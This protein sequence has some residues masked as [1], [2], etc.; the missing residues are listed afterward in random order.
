MHALQPNL[1]LGKLAAGCLRLTR[2]PLLA[3][4]G[5]CALLVAMSA[6]PAFAQ[7]ADLAVTKAGAPLTVGTGAN[8]TYTLSVTNAGPNDGSAVTLTDVLPPG[9]TFVSG[10][11]GCT[12]ALGV[13]TCVVGP[14]VANTSAGATIVVTA[15]SCGAQLTNVVSVA[16]T[17]ID[18]NLL[19][20]TNSAVNTVIDMTAPVIG[21]CP[22]NITGNTDAGVCTKANV[23]WVDPTA[24]DNCTASPAVVCSPASGSTFN[25][26]ATIVTC[27]A[28]DAV[29]LTNACTFT[30]TINDT[31]APVIGACPAN[32]AGNTD[33]G[34]CTKAN[35][36]WTVPGAT[37]NCP[38]VLVACSP[39]SG[40]T[41]AKGATIV[42]CTAT[43][44]VGLTNA[45]TFTVTI[46]DAQAPTIACPAN[47]TTNLT[48]GCTTPVTFTNPVVSDNCPGATFVCVP[49]NGSTFTRGTTTVTCTPTDASL[50]VGAVCTFTVTVTAAAPTISAQPQ[51]QTT[52]MGNG[53]VFSVTAAGT[54]TLTYQWRSNGVP[55]AGATASSLTLANLNLASSGS[56]DV[57]VNN[58]A[59][60]LTS[61]AA[62]LTVTPIYGLSFDFDTAGQYTNLPY[63]LTWNNWVNS[64]FVN[65]PVAMF[66]SP[67]GGVGPFPGSGSLDMIPANASDNTSVLI[68]GSYDFSLPGKTVFASTMF[69]FKTPVTAGRRATQFGFIT[70]TNAGINDVSPQAFM[71]V[72]LQSPTA[73]ANTLE[74]RTQRRTSGGGLQESVFTQATGLTV[75]NWYKLNIGFTN[76]ANLGVSNFGIVAV[77]QDMGPLGTTPGAVVLTMSSTT[78]TADIV[79]FKN[80]F[81]ALRSFE[82][83]GV[84]VRDNTY[85]WTTPGNIA[86]V[87]QPKNLTLTQG[88]RGTFNAMV[89][90]D[91]PYTYQWEKSTDGGATF[92]P[93]AGARDWKYIVPA[94]L[95]TDTLSQ[96]RV[97]VVGPANTVTSTPATLT[98][99]PQTLVVVSA[100][101]VD[102]STVGVMFNQPVNPATAENIANYTINGANPVA[103]RV[104]RTSLSAAGPEGI[105]V[106]L[107]PASI[108]SG[109]FTVV[110][111]GVQDL[112]GGVVGGAN[113]AVGSVANLTGVDVNPITA[114]A[115]ENYSFGPGQFIVTGGGVDLF[116]GFDSFRFVYTTRTG[117]FDVRYRIPF[118][119]SVRFTEKGGV[120]ARWT[121]EPGSPGAFAG[122]NPGPI[123][124]LAG[125]LRSFTE[126]TAKL[127]FGAGG[128]S[129]GNNTRLLQPNVWMRFR[130]AGNS[131]LRY[132]SSDGVTWSCDGQ[133]SQS[134][135]TPFP[136][137]MLVGLAVC[138]ARNTQPASVQ[139]E[140]FGD[141]A[142]YP[143]A[144][145][146]I[147]A[148]P[149]NATNA[150]GSAA[151]IT[152]LTATVTG[153]GIPGQGEMVAYWQRFDGVGWTNMPTAGGTNRNLSV[154]TVFITDNGAQFRAILQAPGVAPVTTAVATL[155]VTDTAVPTVASVAVGAGTVVPSYP[156]SEVVIT[157]S[158][159][160]TAATAT[161]LANYAVTNAAGVKLTVLSASF[162]GNDPRVIVLKVDGQLGTG[163]SSVG[164]SGIRDLNNNLLA[165]VVRTYRSFA[166]SVAPVVIEVY[167]DIGNAATPISALTGNALFTAG[168][169]TYITYSNIFGFNVVSGFANSQ[170][171]YGTKAYTYFL[172]PTNGNYKFWIRSDDVAQLW[173]NTS[174]TNPAGRV[175]IC[176]NTAANGNYTVGTAPASSITNIALVA[177]SPVYMEVLHKEGTGGDGWSVTWT[178]PTVNTAP[179]VT[180]LMPTTALQY[181]D[182][183]AP[184]TPVIAEIYTGFNTFVP[185]FNQLA[186]LY[187]ATNIPVNNYVVQTPGF[188]YLAGLPA[189][190]T[191]QKYFGVQPGLANTRF[192]GYL[193][194]V[195]SYFVAPSNGL[196]RFYCAVDDV[197]QLWMNTNAV[198]STDPAGKTLIGQSANAFVSTA[199]QLMGQNISLVAGQKYYTEVLYRE[200]GGGDGIRL[201]VRSQADTAVPPVTEIIQNNLLEYPADIGR[202]GM[203]GF[204]HIIS[205][206]S[207]SVDKLT[208]TVTEG[209]TL[210]LLPAGI[211]GSLPYGGF[212][213]TKNGVRI[214]ENSFTNYTMPLTLADNGAVFTVQVTNFWSSMTKS[215]TV[216]VLP[217]GVAPTVTRTVGWRYG[218][219][220]TIQFSEPVDALSA[221][222]L[223]NY[224]VNNGLRLLSATLD[225][226]RTMLSVR[227]STQVP[228]TVYTVTV[229]GVK[230]RTAGNTIAA[231]TMVNFSTWKIGGNGILVELFTNIQ[232]S[233][234]ADLTGTTKFQA[235]LPDVLYYTNV[236]GAGLFAG[237]SLLENYGAR[238][239]GYFIPTNT[240]LYRFYI[241]G[242]DGCQLW[243]N[244]NNA[245]SQN[246]AG[247]T[248]LI[249]TPTA[250]INIGNP[251][252]MSAPVS[253]NQGQAYYMEGLM[254]EGGG[255]D[256]FQMT[257]RPTDAAGTVIGTLPVDNAV[258]ENTL[259]TFFGGVP[260]DPTLLG[261]VTGPPADMFVIESDLVTLT[262]TAT[263]PPSLALV[264]AY[265]W[266]RTNGA[267]GFTNI[268]GA[269]LSSYSFYVPLADNDAHY[270]ALFS[271][272]GSDTNF[273]TMFHVTPDGTAPFLQSVGSVDGWSIS[274]RY[275]ELVDTNIAGDNF[276]YTINNDVQIGITAIELQPGGRAADG[277]SYRLML[278][279][280]LT[281]PYTV[282]AFGITDRS[283]ALNTGDSDVAGQVEGFVALD[284]GA[285]TQV[286]ST[287]SFSSNTVD[288]VAGGADIWGAA[289]SGHLTLKQ[290]TGDFDVRA[291]VARLT[292]SA[293]DV[294]AKAGLM[295]REDLNA[296][297]R[298]L[299]QLANP[300]ASISGRDIYEN[301]RR[302][303]PGNVTGAWS[304]GTQN[305]NNGV[306]AGVPNAWVRIKRTGNLFTAYRSAD[307]SSWLATATN[308]LTFSNTVYVGFASTAHNNAGPAVNAD[309]RNIYIPNP[310]SFTLQPT[311]GVQTVNVHDPVSYTVTANNPA[312]SGALTYQW[313]VNGV[314]IP[315]ATS[316]TLNIADASKAHEGVITCWAGNDGGQTISDAVVLNVNNVLPVAGNDTLIATQAVTRTVSAAALLANDTDADPVGL[317]AVSGMAPVTIATDFSAGAPAGTAI[318]GTSAYDVGNGILSL[319]GGGA[320]QAG[321]LII[322]NPYPTKRISAFTASFKVRIT[323]TSAEP[324]DGFS[325]N[326][327]NDIPDAATSAQ[328]AE[329]GAGTG[330]SFCIDNYRFANYPA[331]GTAN[332]SGMKVRYNNVDLVGIQTPSWGYGAF[333][334]VSITVTPTGGCTIMVNNTNAFTL[335]LP[336]YAPALGRFGVFARTG[337]AFES[338]AI[339][340]LNVAFVTADTAAGGQVSESGGTVTYIPP[341]TCGP[342]SFYYVVTD[343]QLNGLSV[344]QVSVNVRSTLPLAPSITTCATNR[345]LLV[346]NSTIELP[347]LIGEVVATVNCGMAVITQSP[348][349]GTLLAPGTH[350]VTLTATDGEGMTATCQAT[351]TVVNVAATVSSPSASGGQ[352]TAGFQSAPGI[353]YVIEYKDNL[354]DPGWTFLMNIVGDGTVKT[355]TDLGP[356][357]PNRYY[358]VRTQ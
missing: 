273:V 61:A 324:A 330:F 184:V 341:V 276:S 46:S 73:A 17:E 160:V 114:P 87:Q 288:V 208:T 249:H 241:R 146:A 338:H 92:N 16:A 41:F 83:G 124:E 217:D 171:N 139:F 247:R 152:N 354:D 188:S 14:L 6:A 265:Q 203:V 314:N 130:R 85:V 327:A 293:A 202:A 311:P 109:S 80:V 248:M 107:T 221:S 345:Y 75:S 347:S 133:L 224:Q 231:N 9:V 344:A 209:Q 177:G 289:D 191:Y 253:L 277:R 250:N 230:D 252:A 239:S 294:I 119:D 301:G 308:T 194:K 183:V 93:I 35:V 236:F 162:L 319:N 268:P 104:Y 90:G 159:P 179:A 36:T 81:L 349:A 50:N 117:D 298:T 64:S 260:G 278:N 299:H 89:D 53:V 137:T 206:A 13:V 322:S 166:P 297:S 113:S 317:Y 266:Q 32:I 40:S 237:N 147:S 66:E 94:A 24:T 125:T 196:Y 210:T 310:P 337:G 185:G 302:E 226:S 306:P 182:A 52:P 70:Q 336:G 234:V 79:Q 106:I 123:G 313:K 300:P 69:K 126:G 174:G 170:D 77:L 78:N 346:T 304:L 303:T 193:G 5:T 153:G 18:P 60:S 357:P 168:T 274:I 334:P 285:P 42:T 167:Q 200:G 287:L 29:G 358:R 71:S 3:L 270:R 15:T 44:A 351:I 127:T 58:C 62:T 211:R 95:T 225:Q 65:P 356:L 309:Y 307:G 328:A 333:I 284:V 295:V 213:W 141:F 55:I 256:Y 257:F 8:I 98:V 57:V 219:G 342:D 84:D 207:Q 1:G 263:V 140:S 178:D 279:Q 20:N 4:S 142:G 186:G 161:L 145:I 201:S 335:A 315:G 187:A 25:K 105:Y 30:V 355:F 100:G 38:G 19:D 96:Y 156:V 157:F 143:G 205:T 242:D 99:T 255:G 135:I 27:T 31:E 291:R 11:A 7:T 198:N 195:Y 243:M 39:I 63:Y 192:D 352:F 21:A 261:T 56:F 108:L 331:G 323:D 350:I 101:S 199:S 223:G 154:G 47:I 267:G 176:E 54:S 97:T 229:N 43:D 120:D 281:G 88:A 271:S 305:G 214:L 312:N 329:N 158:E 215:I 116:S 220:F 283:V 262:V 292:R 348:L 22:A 49:A 343:G 340:D 122:F 339:D 316:A 2:K 244:I 128:T 138:S 353:N 12:E 318:Y 28:T 197:C 218:D 212:V 33:V 144:T 72:I 74:F 23:T 233:A 259:S 136:A 272:P 290:R 240:G 246:P 251:N 118:M 151:T 232:G 26:G 235:S 51:N 163:N 180:V 296:N 326:F 37:D 282:Q 164:I 129:W 173:M 320:S 111:T 59:G 258:A 148:Q 103:A 165:T 245:D 228:N 102:G 216:N 238:I 190:V 275:N 280:Q 45:C 222:Y 204:N 82:D 67:L 181:P 86:F 68:A 264:S 332:T 254:K 169:P 134:L 150:A 286:G 155:T 321:S 325:F 269:N 91:G 172:P 10:S 149:M 132:Q 131:F 110:A 115:G 227:T 121:L 189:A 76:T 175:L 34:V 48:A 112:S